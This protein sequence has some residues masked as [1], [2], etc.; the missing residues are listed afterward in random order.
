MEALFASCSEEF[1]SIRNSQTQQAAAAEGLKSE[2]IALN[3]KLQNLDYSINQQLQNLSHRI[4][5]LEARPTGA[6][7]ASADGAPNPVGRP[8]ASAGSA[9]TG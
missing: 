2:M 1:Q 5:A 9:A 4:S 7:S 8:L 6:Q 3:Q